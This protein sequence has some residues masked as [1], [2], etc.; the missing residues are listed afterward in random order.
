MR[1][2]TQL[3]K[4]Y[5]QGVY[6]MIKVRYCSTNGDGAFLQIRHLWGLFY[7]TSH[8]LVSDERKAEA[9]ML[10]AIDNLKKSYENYDKAVA[11]SKFAKAIIKNSKSELLHTSAV[12]EEHVSFKQWLASFGMSSIF[13][14][15]PDTWKKVI[16]FIRKSGGGIRISAANMKVSMYQAATESVRIPTKGE[17]HNHNQGG[18]KKKNRNGEHC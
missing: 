8:Y 4:Q 2:R 9:K 15:Q 3:T 5:Q 17:V 14:E 18:K 11:K 16:A 10:K 13:P 1:S 6:P 12:F 7:T